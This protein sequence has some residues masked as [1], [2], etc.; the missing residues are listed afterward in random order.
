MLVLLAAAGLGA[1]ADAAGA[2]VVLNEINCEG[3]DWVELVNTGPDAADISGWLLTDDPLDSTRAD[4]RHV[5]GDPTSIP[6]SDD[7]VVERGGAGFPFGISCGSDT[8][9]LADASP[10]L[11]DETAVPE[12]TVGGNTWGRYPNGSGPWAETAPTKG[13]PNEPSAGGEDDAAGW[14]FKPD[15]VVEVD[16]N[17]PQASIDALDADPDT[18]VP[19]TFSLETTGGSYGPLDVGVHLKGR[20]GSFR[21]LSGKAAFK[22]KFNEFVGGQR[23]LGLEKLTLNNMVQDPSMVHEVLAYEA[24]R[25]AGVDAPRTGYAYVRVNGADYGVY[26]N[27]ETIDSVALRRWFDSTQHL[28]EAEY[29]V[30]A[31]PGWSVLFEVDEGNEDDRSDLEALADAAAAT[32][33]ADLSERVAG[34][35]DLQQMTSMWAVERYIGHWDGYSGPLINNYYLHSDADGLFSML[36]WGTDQTWQDHVLFGAGLSRLFSVCWAD[37]GCAAM[38]RQ[39]VLDS[40]SAIMAAGMD[41]LATET[42]ATLEPWQALDPRMESSPEAID[43]ELAATRAFIASRPADVDAWLSEP[44]ETSITKAPKA[45]QWLRGRRERVEFQFASSLAGSA[46]EC[47]LDDNL[48]RACSSPREYRVRAGRHEFRVWTE[49]PAGPTAESP[50]V[51]RFRVVER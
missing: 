13:A 49:S 37:A 42:A 22:L 25:A 5:F 12:L 19:G 8:I 21:P 43:A 11:L 10:T 50:A 29:G 26:L 4:H 38:Y 30:D 15:V 27:I 47:R 14:M 34:L 9:R 18:Y 51:A 48:R 28:Y 23:F 1:R 6:A 45:V 36:P 39:A 16:L 46:F 41:S 24:F 44:P 35:A 17:L 7:L 31:Q 2:A 3:T 20:A 40:R 33:P 32:A